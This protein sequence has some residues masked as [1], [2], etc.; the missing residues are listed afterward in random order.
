MVV[1]SSLWM[2]VC[3]VWVTV[4]VLLFL[5]SQWNSGR[6]LRLAWDNVED[7]LCIQDDGSVLVYDIFGSFKRTFSMGQ[8]RASSPLLM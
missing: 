1:T 7:L 8:V 6:V 4:F 3:S 5:C 2:L